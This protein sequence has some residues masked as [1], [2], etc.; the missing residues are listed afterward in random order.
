MSTHALQEQRY[1]DM[2]NSVVKHK[3]HEVLQWIAQGKDI[4]IRAGNRWCKRSVDNV[5]YTLAH[6]QDY[7][8]PCDFRIKP[9]STT[10]T[11]SG[12]FFL[13]NAIIGYNSSTITLETLN[14]VF[15]GDFV[16]LNSGLVR[17]ISENWYNE[18]VSCK[19]QLDKQTLTKGQNK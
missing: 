7:V 13:K 18:L 19:E 8:E 1:R 2:K 4:E 12:T 14:D 11:I 9:K 10:K 3:F 5:L 15:V 17:I 16:E 6:E